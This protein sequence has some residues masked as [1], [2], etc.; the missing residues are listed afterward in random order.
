MVKRE[1]CSYYDLRLQGRFENEKYLSMIVDGADQAK[2]R[3]PHF[4]QKTSE[5]LA[6]KKN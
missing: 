1:R 5:R 4:A 2:F 3:L 6:L